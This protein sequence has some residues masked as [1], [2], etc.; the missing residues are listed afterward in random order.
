MENS[1]MVLGSKGLIRKHEFLLSGNW[2]GCI[3]TLNAIKD[4]MDE[5]RASALFLVFKQCLLECLNR[6]D[7]AMAL[8]VLRKAVSASRLGKDKA[9]NLAG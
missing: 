1:S 4:L 7:D 3:D 9:Q 6:G 8:A 5:T 2:N